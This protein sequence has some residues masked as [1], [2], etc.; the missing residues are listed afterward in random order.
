MYLQKSSERTSQHS[1]SDRRKDLPQF[2]TS[3][4]HEVD[5][6][7]RLVTEIANPVASGD[8]GC[9]NTALERRNFMREPHIIRAQHT[10]ADAGFS[11]SCDSA[12]SSLAAVGG[13]DKEQQSYRNL[14]S[15]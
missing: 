8:V 10:K 7:I 2:L 13:S 12:G 4:I 6:V 5:E 9:S 15:E 11:E 1:P 3:G 14:E